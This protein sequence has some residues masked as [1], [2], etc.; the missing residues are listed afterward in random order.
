MVKYSCPRCGYQTNNKFDMKRHYKRKKI[1]K[2]KLKDIKLDENSIEP[3]IE[4]KCEHCEKSY[5]NKSNLNKHI[6]ICKNK[7]GT[8]RID[9]KTLTLSQS[10][11]EL[12]KDELLK[13]VGELN[14]Q[15]EKKDNSDKRIDKLE[16]MIENTAGNG[17]V[18][19]ITQNITQN[20]VIL[21]YNETDVS[22]IKDLDYY[23]II[24]RCI[25]SVPRLIEK[26]HF[27]P[28][29]PEN[30]NIYISNLSKNYAMVWNGKQWV[31]KDQTEVLEDLIA[32]NEYRLEDWVGEGSKKYPK[33]MK[34]LKIWT[35]KR[36]EKGVPEMIRK[37]VKMMMYNNREMIKEI[38]E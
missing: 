14:K 12:S 5:S 24:S 25:M 35:T 4:F 7:E 29:K 21:P 18:N 30:H 28:D 16:K 22:H 3:F 13:L 6:E 36:D 31:T 38:K 23:N 26:T 32:E 20:I 8:S 37:E 10:P 34:K 15:L 17:T 2:P 9:P 11:S 19:N 27:N 33:A 1:C